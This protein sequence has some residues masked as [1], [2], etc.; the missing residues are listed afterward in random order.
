MPEVNDEGIRPYIKFKNHNRFVR[1][2]FL[3][4]DDFE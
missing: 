1:V 4:Y 2:P 3:I